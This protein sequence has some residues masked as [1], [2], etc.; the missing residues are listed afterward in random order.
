MRNGF[1]KSYCVF[2]L[3]L[4][5]KFSYKRLQKFHQHLQRLTMQLGTHRSF[6]RRLSLR[7]DLKNAVGF[8]LMTLK[9]RFYQFYIS[10]TKTT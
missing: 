4:L 10:F 1:E 5:N 9:K 7:N 6:G 8:V 2:G 3:D